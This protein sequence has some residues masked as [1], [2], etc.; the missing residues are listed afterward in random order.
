MEF[1]NG[2]D[3]AE[4]SL[5]HAALARIGKNIVQVLL[6]TA[7]AREI[8]VDKFRGFLL[9]DAQLLREAEW[10]KAVY[11]AEIDGLGGAAVLPILRHRPH[12]ENFLRPPRVDVFPVAE[13]LDEHRVA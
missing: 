6:H 3:S 8:G 7:I 12:A 2:A 10:R 4:Q 9:L 1:R 5:R 13:C 11:D